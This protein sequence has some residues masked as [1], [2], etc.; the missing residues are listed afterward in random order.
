M[1][2]LIGLNMTLL[3]MDN[4]LKAKALCHTAYIDAVAGAGGIPILIPP[5]TDMSMLERALEPLDG[6]CLIGGPDYLPS[7]YG[8]REQPAADLMHSRRHHFD[9]ALA[10]ILLRKK[11]RTPVLGICGGHQ[12]ISIALGGALV[13]DLRS[14]WKPRDSDASTLLHANVERKG[15]PQEDEGYRHEIRIEKGTR[16]AKIVGVTKLLTN[17]YHHQALRTD[18]M[19][20]GLVVSAW[21]PDG[22]IEAIES[23]DAKRFLLGVQWHPERQQQEAAHKAVFTALVEASKDI[24]R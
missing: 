7:H 15:T 3:D 18:R 22:V 10:D 16:M 1:R 5:Y 8:G 24:N 13:Q 20:E 19:G 9:L 2:P 6:F 21:A 23:K 4:P 12:L 11:E 17:S 14:E